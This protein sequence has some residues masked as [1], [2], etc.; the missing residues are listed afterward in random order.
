M[1]VGCNST[2]DHAQLAG[3]TQWVNTKLDNLVHIGHGCFV[4]SN[5]AM[6]TQVGLAGGVKVEISYLRWALEWGGW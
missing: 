4:G 2:I 1:R 6:A 3:E 5:C